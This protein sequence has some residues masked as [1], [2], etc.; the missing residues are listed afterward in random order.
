MMKNYRTD[1]IIAA[2]R[3]DYDLPET[4]LNY[5]ADREDE[6]IKRFSFVDLIKFFIECKDNGFDKTIEKYEL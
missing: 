2:D 5:L 6:M 1:L 3:A 4:Q